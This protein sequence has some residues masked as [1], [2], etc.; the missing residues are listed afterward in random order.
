LALLIGYGADSAQGFLF[1]APLP[2][3]RLTQWLI[4]SPFGTPA[5][6]INAPRRASRTQ[7][8]PRRKTPAASTRAR[9]GSRDDPQ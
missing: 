6:A 9:S 1:S 8:A 3:D 7:G 5:T 4:D 2:A